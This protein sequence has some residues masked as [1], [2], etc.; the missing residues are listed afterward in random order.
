[1]YKKII[2]VHQFY[3][4]YIYFEVF[5]NSFLL[6]S[7][8]KYQIDIILCILSLHKIA[9]GVPMKQDHHTHLLF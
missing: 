1:M 6:R 7:L 3:R 9:A 2:F 5:D 8:W 4:T